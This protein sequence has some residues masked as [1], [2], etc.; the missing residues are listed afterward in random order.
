MTFNWTP[1]FTFLFWLVIFWGVLYLLARVFHL[2]KR[3]LDVN[4]A[5]LMYRS[6]SLNSFIDKVA[7]KKPVVWT[8]LS[9]IGLVMGL[10]IM[11]FALYFFIN[12]LITFT[13]GGEAAQVAPLIPGLT[14]SL[15]WLPSFYLMN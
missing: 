14:L 4:F 2:D 9:Y 13:Q 11:A 1:E 5:Y 3:G 15:Y 8:V 12:N 10:G 7:K 6:P